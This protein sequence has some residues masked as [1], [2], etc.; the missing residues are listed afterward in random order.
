MNFFFERETSARIIVPCVHHEK[1][2]NNNNND[3]EIIMKMK[4]FKRMNPVARET[5][6]VLYSYIRLGGWGGGGE[7]ENRLSILSRIYDC[8]W[9]VRSV[10][11]SRPKS[12]VVSYDA[13]YVNYFTYIQT[14]TSIYIYNKNKQPLYESYFFYPPKK[15]FSHL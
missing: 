4:I 9:L 8:V 14:H 2:N 6:I 7:K 12:R 5:D 11:R 15:F 1:N 13:L 3:D 10:S